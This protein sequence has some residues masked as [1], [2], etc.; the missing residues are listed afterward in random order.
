MLLGRSAA[1]VPCPPPYTASPGRAG[2]SR[3]PGFSMVHFLLGVSR[4]C[5]TLWCGGAFL[6]VW[7][8]VRDILSGQ[9]ESVVLDQLLLNHFA[10]FYYFSFGFLPVGSV[11]LGAVVRHPRSSFHSRLGF[12]LAMGGLMVLLLDY[13]F[14]FSPLRDMLLPIGSPRPQGFRG[15]HRLSECLNALTFLLNLAAA[16][17]LNFKAGLREHHTLE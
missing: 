15:Y 12:G 6:F 1:P 3:E 8:T 9:F 5:L 4:F 16:A 14:V 2:N 7:L 10:V 17:L 11:C 13:F